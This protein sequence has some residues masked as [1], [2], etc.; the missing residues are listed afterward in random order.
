MIIKTDFTK[1]IK[2]CPICN[3]NNF[4]FPFNTQDGNLL[5][6]RTKDDG[7]TI[8]VNLASCLKCGYIMLFTEPV[9]SD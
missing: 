4:H 5:F 7:Y 6:M 3:N 2:I 1:H 9:K 8:P